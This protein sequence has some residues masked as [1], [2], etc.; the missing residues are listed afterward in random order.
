MISVFPKFVLACKSNEIKNRD[1]PGPEL[2]S[3]GIPRIDPFRKSPVIA[4]SVPTLPTFSIDQ[5]RK[6][7]PSDK[8]QPEPEPRNQEK[9]AN[10]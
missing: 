10:S 8:P 3:E 5:V 1:E 7:V 2:A 4:Q 9:I 6:A